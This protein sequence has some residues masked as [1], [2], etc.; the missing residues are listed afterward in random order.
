MSTTRKFVQVSC[1][2]AP[3]SPLPPPSSPTGSTQVRFCIPRHCSAHQPVHP[4][5]YCCKF[6]PSSSRAAPHPG[7]AS[8]GPSRSPMRF[9]RFSPVASFPHPARTGPLCKCSSIH[10]SHVPRLC[11]RLWRLYP[12]DQVRC[13]YTIH[14]SPSFLVMQGHLVFKGCTAPLSRGL[15]H[16]GLGS[17]SP[18]PPFLALGLTSSTGVC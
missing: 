4:Q 12:Y 14:T 16:L 2:T 15:G 11:F 6:L 10:V 3:P 13:L 5:D 18:L 8:P 7:P 9:V 1:P 17:G